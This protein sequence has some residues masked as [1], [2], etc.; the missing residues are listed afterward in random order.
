MEAGPGRAPEVLRGAHAMTDVTGFGLAGHLMSICR[1]SG[2]GAEIALDQVPVYSGALELSEKGV[3]S[4]LYEANRANA[5][6]FGPD[7]AAMALLHDP[8]T[9]A[10]F[11]AAVAE[12][13]AEQVLA[14]L[15]EAGVEAAR[16]GQM[17]QGPVGITLI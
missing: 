9:A 16:I 6:V 1:A 4:T 11:L 7:T 5:P 15:A 3:R 2:L 10:G 17:T 12:D 13:E 8:Q 14:D